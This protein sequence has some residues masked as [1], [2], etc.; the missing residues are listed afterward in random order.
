MPSWTKYAKAVILVGSVT[1]LLSGCAQSIDPGKV[2][3]AP[4]L[5]DLTED[6]SGD[7]V[8]PGVDPDAIIALTENRVAWAECRRLHRDTVQFYEGIAAQLR[9]EN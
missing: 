5:P 2:A 7:C 3:V 9:G 6:L 4:E 1:A 8:D